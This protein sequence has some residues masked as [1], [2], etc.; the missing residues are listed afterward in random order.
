MTPEENNS[1]KSEKAA[2]RGSGA[3]QSEF[4]TPS[5]ML[6][7]G[8]AK[9]LNEPGIAKSVAEFIAALAKNKS[10]EP[11]FIQTSYGIGLLFGLLV[12]FGIGLLGWLKVIGPEATTGLLGAL[13][14]YWY[15]RE[16]GGSKR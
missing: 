3:Q 2:S 6:A 13:I 5:E 4:M 1:Q 12:F 14:G 11:R 15:G 10:L 9:L 8:A 16:K 7:E